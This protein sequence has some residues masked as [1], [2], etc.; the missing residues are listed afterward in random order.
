MCVY[1]CCV[2]VM[3]MNKKIV[4]SYLQK[5]WDKSGSHQLKMSRIRRKVKQQA[6][7]GARGIGKDGLPAS[8]KGKINYQ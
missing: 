3:L 5:R 2:C 7:V 8:G 6:V 1:V 4:P